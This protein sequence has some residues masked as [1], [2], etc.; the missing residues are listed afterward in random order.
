MGKQIPSAIIFQGKTRVISQETF[1]IV[2]LWTKLVLHWSVY[3]EACIV[4]KTDEILLVLS[5]ELLRLQP[6]NYSVLAAGPQD[7]Q[8]PI[9]ESSGGSSR[10]DESYDYVAW[11]TAVSWNKWDCLIWKR[12]A[13]NFQLCNRL[14]WKERVK[15]IFFVSLANTVKG[16]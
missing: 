7:R 5:R 11:Y 3:T 8:V 12:P 13:N 2:M 14:L 16:I 10:N 9:T 1:N 4:C 6:R 15:T